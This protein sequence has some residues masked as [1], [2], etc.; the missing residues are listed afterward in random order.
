MHELRLDLKGVHYAKV[1]QLLRGF[2]SRFIGTGYQ[3]EV[4]IGRSP[5]VRSEAEK[6]VKDL[7]LKYH[8]IGPYRTLDDYLIIK[9][10]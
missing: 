9:E 4:C 3:V 6:V 5:M 1:Y 10:V 8:I 2:T 7:G